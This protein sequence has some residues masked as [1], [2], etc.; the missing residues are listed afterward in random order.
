MIVPQ[1]AVDFAG[2][3]DNNV[4]SLEVSTEFN[5]LRVVRT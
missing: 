5:V 4:V 3:F 1:C 2:S